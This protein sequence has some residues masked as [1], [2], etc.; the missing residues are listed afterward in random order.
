MEEYIFQRTELLLGSGVMEQLAQKKVILFGV[1]GVGSWCAE[2]LVRSGIIHLTLVD[3]DRVAVSNINRQLPATSE[4]LGKPKVEVLK[5]R[6]Q[7]INPQARITAL[8]Q[9][10]E[11]ENSA[12]FQLDTYDYIL[13]AIDSLNNKI[14]LIQ[15]ATQTK[16]TLFSSMGAALKMDPTRIRVA[17]FWKVQGCPLAA[18]LRQRMRKGEKPAKKFLCVYSDELLPHARKDNVNGTLMHV[19]ATFGL[20]LASMVI[21]EA[22]SLNKKDN[23]N[24]FI[25]N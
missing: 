25:M 13:D 7:S 2:S 22:H 3:F 20:V 23:P 4:T 11:P 15:A 10:Y 14:H 19:T 5:E 12:S 1:G 21:R 8:E 17:E 16:A 9:K 6:L 18:A 24:R